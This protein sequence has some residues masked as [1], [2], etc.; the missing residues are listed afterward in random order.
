MAESWRVERRLITR[1]SLWVRR[2]WSG[3]VLYINRVSQAQR[4]RFAD[5]VVV[6]FSQKEGNG[7][8]NKALR[9]QIRSVINIRNDSSLEVV[10]TIAFIKTH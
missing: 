6:M 2:S 10:R 8:I 4:R 5:V 1:W 7:N 3:S 9:I